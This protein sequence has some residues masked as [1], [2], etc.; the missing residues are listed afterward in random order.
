MLT[1]M[2]ELRLTPCVYCL[3]D[4]KLAKREAKESRHRYSDHDDG[5]RHHERSYRRDS[6]D[7]NYS[8][9]RSSHRRSRSPFE[10]T[11]RHRSRQESLERGRHNDDYER[12]ERHGDHDRRPYPRT[13]R[14]SP[15]RSD[16]PPRGDPPSRR[17]DD[18]YTQ[19]EPYNRRNGFPATRHED[20]RD[21]HRAPSRPEAL[22]LDSRPISSRHN[23]ADN[24]N[25]HPHSNGYNSAASAGLTAAEIRAQKLAQMQADALDHSATRLATLE[26]RRKQDEARLAEENRVREQRG[27]VGDT[28]GDYVRQQ[29]QYLM[30]GGMDLAD[31][32]GRRG[33]KGLLREDM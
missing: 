3:Q 17:R 11:P 2:T 29:E 25:H 19:D 14:D 24:G 4:R 27:K 1:A 16:T 6:G 33:G 18:G 23:G 12:R 31:V 28:K 21:V 13:R 20:R 10:R 30:G 32:L 26:E 8:H 22:D 7:G 9:S 5:Y 15:S